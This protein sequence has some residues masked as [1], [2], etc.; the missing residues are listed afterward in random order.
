MLTYT[1]DDELGTAHL[2]FGVKTQ[3]LY[4]NRVECVKSACVHT[5]V[6]TDIVCHDLDLN[7]SGLEPALTAV[8]DDVLYTAFPETG[9]P[10]RFVVYFDMMDPVAFM[11]YP[12]VV[13]CTFRF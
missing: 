12:G 9:E 8:Y 4:E 1:Y 2:Y 6:G 7:A 13:S 11:Q 5:L 10:R 3:L